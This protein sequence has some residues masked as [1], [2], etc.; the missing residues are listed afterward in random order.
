MLKNLGYSGAYHDPSLSIGVLLEDPAECG[1]EANLLVFSVTVSG[2]QESTA[3]LKM[4]DF[5]FYIMDEQDRLYNTQK[6]PGAQPSAQIDE[7]DDELFRRPDG[8]IFTEF[9]HEFLFQNL[10]MVIYSRQ[11]QQ[12]HIFALRY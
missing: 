9:K 11:D 10:R 8:L 5:S 6:L 4:E 3:H 12:F 2:K 7:E 1:L